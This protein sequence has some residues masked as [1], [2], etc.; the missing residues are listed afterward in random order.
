[1]AVRIVFFGTHDFAAGILQGLL[2]SP[3]FIVKLVITQPD[4]P[5]GRE[6]KITLPPVKLLAKKNNLKIVQPSTL[7]NFELPNEFDLGIVAQYGLLIPANILNV[8]K[9]GVL[10]V[11]PSLLP[12]Y[13]GAS[14]IQSAILN[15]EKETGVS[16]MKLDTGMDTGPVLARQKIALGSD[17][18]YP[19]LSKKLK[20][21]AIPLLLDAAKR[22]TQ[23]EIWPVNQNN[24]MAV[25]C[26]ELKRE[27]GKIDWEESAK[28]IYNKWRAY[29]PWP[30]IFSEMKIK[31]KQIRLKFDKIKIGM[32]APVDSN[33]G[34]IIKINKKEIGI[35]AGD[36]QLIL[37]GEI[38]PEG[39][40][41]MTAKNF[42]NGYL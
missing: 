1:M 15:G 28:K 30:G 19:D 34:E 31:N 24:D 18:T 33:P 16:I 22:Y 10:N 14:P 5:F 29:Q 3:D 35:V 26:R 2:E 9:F 38:Q 4:K 17:E 27:D 7:N 6:Q 37:V 12:K 13:R 40:K 41:N 23:G 8:P 36:K 25:Y 20:L 39:K 32:K 42:I 21:A 11:H